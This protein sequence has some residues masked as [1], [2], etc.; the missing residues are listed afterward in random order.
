MTKCS[1]KADIVLTV[2]LF[3][4]MNSCFQ[5]FM[6]IQGVGG[7]L[8]E[9]CECLCRVREVP[10]PQKHRY[11]IECLYIPPMLNVCLLCCKRYMCTGTESLVLLFFR[12]LNNTFVFAGKLKVVERL[13]VII[14]T[15]F[16]QDEMCACVILSQN[17][18]HTHTDDAAPLACEN[19]FMG[20]MDS[21]KQIGVMRRSTHNLYFN[22]E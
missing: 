10:G 9:L 13:R 3:C 5:S 19:P 14:C 12:F 21:G 16:V 7:S 18:T 4:T 1:F 11:P 15:W 8:K 6:S 2:L 20:T 17:I 22:F